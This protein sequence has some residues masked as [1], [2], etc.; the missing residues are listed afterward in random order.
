MRRYYA[1]R[2]FPRDVVLE[3]PDATDTTENLHFS[4][5]LLEER[6][7]RDPVIVVCTSDFHVLRTER[8][9]GM[10][11]V[12]RGGNGR[13]FTAVVLGAP[14]P[15]PVIPASYLREYVALTLHRVLGRA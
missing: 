15:K 1:R 4:L 14:T 5:E 12:E 2:G 3:E 10:L 11:Q 9:A 6:G 7:V 8:I 13:P